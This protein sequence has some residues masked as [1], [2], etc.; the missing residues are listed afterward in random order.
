MSK[1]ITI[2]LSI[3]C[4]L[5]FFSCNSRNNTTTATTSHLSSTYPSCENPHKDGSF[6]RIDRGGTPQLPIY[7][8]P[9]LRAKTLA[10]MARLAELPVGALPLPLRPGRI[11]H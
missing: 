8:A 1:T 2:L 11:F 5:L 10:K 3:S 9:T 4:G 7:R 6:S